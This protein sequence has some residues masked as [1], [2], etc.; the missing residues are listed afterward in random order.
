[1]P[2]KGHIQIPTAR[3]LPIMSDWLDRGGRREHLERGKSSWKTVTAS[4][5]VD[6]VVADNLLTGLGR[7]DAWYVELADLHAELLGEAA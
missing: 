5:F 2:A 3:L 6:E 4:E 7:N 1:M